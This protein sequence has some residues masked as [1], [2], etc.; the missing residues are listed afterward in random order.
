MKRILLLGGIGEAL[1]LARRLAVRHQVI[2]SLAGRARVPELPCRVRIGGFGGVDGLVEWFAGRRC[3]LLIDATHPY[4][5]RI[6]EHGAAAARHAGVA[7]WAYRRP[8]WRPKPG[9]DWRE[10]AD[11][12]DLAVMLENY[13]RPFFTM[14]LEPLRYMNLIPESQRWL[15]R[16][17]DTS[18]PVA[19]RVTV[20]RAVGPF[21]LDVE[22][23]VFR[24][25]QVD[26]LV[27]K[28]SGGAA[29]AT[30]LDAARILGIPVAIWRRPE[31][32]AVKATFTSVQAL[33]ERLSC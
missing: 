8:P 5:V 17:I 18:M 11:W 1:T 13:R 21:G 32:P 4:A 31:L 30:K 16:V 3:D 14:G 7:L 6:S 12:S 27:T 23:D 24:R 22:L 15:V 29:V 26:L 2:Y 19:E 10:I 25:Y 9:D 28:N 33:A 20:I